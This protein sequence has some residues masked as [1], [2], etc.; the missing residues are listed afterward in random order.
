VSTLLRLYR[1]GHI[2]AADPVALP[3]IASSNLPG[4]LRPQGDAQKARN[5]WRLGIVVASKL[6]ELHIVGAPAAEWDG[7]EQQDAKRRNIESK[8]TAVEIM[9][10]YVVG[11]EFWSF[12]PFSS[13]SEFLS[14]AC[15]HCIASLQAPTE[16]TCC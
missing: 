14:T 1:H 16:R 4:V 3:P 6:L 15:L 9:A 12:S 8:R 7:E 11:F 5:V 10:N 13:C 2:Q